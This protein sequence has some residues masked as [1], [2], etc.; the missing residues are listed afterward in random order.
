MDIDYNLLF[1][2]FGIRYLRPYQELIIRYILECYEDDR[3]G[4]LLAVLPTGSGKSLCFM[5]PLLHLSRRAILIYPL[6]SLM[7]D[8]EKRLRAAGI[9]CVVLRGGRGMGERRRRL[10]YIREHSGCAVITNPEMLIAMEKRSELNALINPLMLVLDEAHTAVT[11]SSFRPSFLAIRG[12]I[13]SLSPKMVLA[14]T[15]TADSYIGKGLLN[16]VFSGRKTYLVHGNTDREN[17]FYHEIRSL[18]KIHDIR[19]LISPARPSIIFVPSRSLA[20]RIASALSDEFP[21]R[22]YHAGME[23]EKKKEIEDWFIASEDGVLVGTSAF[24]MG[25]DK[26]S[27]RSVIHYSLPQDAS[28]F[29][30][31]AGRGGRDGRRM[32]SYVL[33]YPYEESPIADIFRGEGCIRHKLLAAM[34]DNTEEDGCIACSHCSPDGIKAQGED[35]IIRFIRR[36]PL[37]KR[38]SIE[39]YLCSSSPI[40]RRKRL[41]GW[42]EK[43]I[44]RAIGILIEE[45]KIKMILGR[46]WARKSIQHSQSLHNQSL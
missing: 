36:H 34:G 1:S 10:R 15:A 29:L 41:P 30:Q 17:I 35:T 25:I 26:K 43:D 45:G 40:F 46:L 19:T 23:R 14:F 5:Y 22:A 2:S 33:Y 9:D 44:S 42:S 8:Q 39:T 11:W 21:A 13:D 4:N 31:E 37:W 24:G 12:I 20:E 7:N 16:T 27:V 38:R 32:D 18:S 28:E 6:L 3:Q